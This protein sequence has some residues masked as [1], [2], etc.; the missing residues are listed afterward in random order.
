MLSLAISAAM[1]IVAFLFLHGFGIIQTSQQPISSINSIVAIGEPSFV[2][3]YS[4]MK[5][6]EFSANKGN[7]DSAFRLGMHHFFVTLKNDDAIAWFRLSAKCPNMKY[8]DGLLAA[9][10]AKHDRRF[11][12]E[13]DRIILDMKK[14]DPKRANE[15]ER[16][17]LDARLARS[18]GHQ[19]N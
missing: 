9:L 13:I 15:L 16:N 14:I 7:C 19:I 12:V 17:V 6:L 3:S 2:V 10:L 1:I 18:Q 8:K 11:D 5:E 4:E